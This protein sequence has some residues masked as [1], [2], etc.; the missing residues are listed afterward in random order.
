MSDNASILDA[1]VYEAI[2][3]L[4]L[5]ANTL[6]LSSLDGGNG[7]VSLVQQSG[8]AGVPNQGGAPGAGLAQMN[9]PASL[10][11]G[12]AGFGFGPNTAPAGSGDQGQTAVASAV[13]PAGA[14]ASSLGTTS[15]LASQIAAP[16]AGAVS[17]VNARNGVPG[18]SSATTINNP[19]TGGTGS[20][21]LSPILGPSGNQDSDLSLGL[22]GLPGG[23][24]TLTDTASTATSTASLVHDT[25][26]TMIGTV[27]SAANSLTDT[28]ASLTGAATGAANDSLSTL[29][30][31]LTTTANATT[32]SL[33]DTTNS[34]LG[35]L[36]GVVNATTS[37]ASPL[38]TS[39]GTSSL[40]GSTSVLDSTL[41]STG[42]ATGT[43][44]GSLAT[45]TNTLTTTKSLIGV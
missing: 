2:A 34:L 25:D 10:P 11:G 33:A 27:N 31:N 15:N 45:L 19:A 26:A 1:K 35:V 30:A 16:L 7:T 32:A 24:G 22:G 14:I 37:T 13:S 5:S 6:P 12:T 43:S 8:P 3:S 44:T 36:T 29:A 38:V 17:L 21:L 20:G 18:A 9:T 4:G 23:T 42:T 28:A 41:S 40:P 39:I